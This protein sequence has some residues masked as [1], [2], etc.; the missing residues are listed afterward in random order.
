MVYDA[1]YFRINS[2]LHINYCPSLSYFSTKGA[3][4][5]RKTVIQTQHSFKVDWV[6]SSY[7]IVC[8]RWSQHGEEFVKK[9]SNSGFSGLRLCIKKPGPKLNKGFRST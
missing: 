8:Y 5:F 4:I 2:F 7:T 1:Y 6:R 9:L 3:Q